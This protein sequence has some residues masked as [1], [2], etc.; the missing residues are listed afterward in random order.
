MNKDKPGTKNVSL[1]SRSI[2]LNH[3]T[4]FD[5]K[6]SDSATGQLDFEGIMSRVPKFK[7]S[8]EFFR[9]CS[10]EECDVTEFIQVRD[11]GHFFNKEGFDS[12]TPTI[13]KKS[14]QTKSLFGI[15][16]ML[17]KKKLPLCQKHHLEFE[18]GI[19]SKLDPDKLSLVFSSVHTS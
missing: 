3:P 12:G 19:L 2:I 1:I 15:L 8:L 6:T 18:K 13:L 7:Q 17:N 11:T 14:K 5:L 4:K 10:V 16:T 9:S